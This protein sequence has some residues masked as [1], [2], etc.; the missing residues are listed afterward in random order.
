VPAATTLPETAAP[1]AQPQAY[2]PP[3]Q[4]PQGAYPQQPYPQQPYPEQ[5]QPAPAQGEQQ[6]AAQGPCALKEFCFGPMFTL[7]IANLIGLGAH[8]RYGQYVGFGIDYQFTPTVGI[9]DVDVNVWL[10]TVDGR[11]YPPGDSLFLSLGFAYQKLSAETSVTFEGVNVAANGD[12]GVPLLKVGMGFLG[13]DGF[14][15]GIDLA[16]EIPLSGIHTTLDSTK[17]TDP[18]ALAQY[19]MLKKD[20]EDAADDVLNILPFLLQLNLIRIGYMF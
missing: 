18:A 6:P 14:V 17:P 8:A 11:V 13:H 12:A 3:A 7:G 10:L 9:E 1:V 15:M 2:P 4:Y 5:Q 16:L 20:I 19:N